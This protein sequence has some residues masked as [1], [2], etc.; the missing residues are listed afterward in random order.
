[1]NRIVFA[2]CVVTLAGLSLPAFAQ[3]FDETVSYIQDRCVGT[4]VT[5][6]YSGTTPARISTTQFSADQSG[7]LSFRHRIAW[8][9]GRS[10]STSMQSFRV[11]LSD[12]EEIKDDPGG[13]SGRIGIRARGAI[14]SDLGNGPG[15]LSE[16][17]L[18]CPNRDRIVRAL[19]HLVSLADD[20]PF[21]N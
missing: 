2:A 13:N 21:A 20:D 10:P 9:D 1:M 4:S 12:I 3:S 7:S 5:Y 17:Y 8:S 15:R 16:T 14:I 18:Y 6:N 19:E 11:P